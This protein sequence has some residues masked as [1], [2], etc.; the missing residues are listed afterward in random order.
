MAHHKT[1]R[2]W[3]RHDAARMKAKARRIYPHDAEAKSANHLAIC[4]CMGCGNPRAWWGSLTLQ[5][6]RAADAA[7]DD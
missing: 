3:R 7:R 2:A 5:E 1:G 4:S 6:L